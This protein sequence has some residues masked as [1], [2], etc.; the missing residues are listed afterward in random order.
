MEDS[1]HV[2]ISSRYNTGNF[3]RQMYNARESDLENDSEG[4]GDTIFEPIK[5]YT[6]H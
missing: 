3:V 5:M 4:K 1:S 6:P 2:S